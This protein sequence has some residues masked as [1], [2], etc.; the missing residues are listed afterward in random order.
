MGDVVGVLLGNLFSVGCCSIG[1]WFWGRF[2]CL[3]LLYDFG[4]V[5]GFIR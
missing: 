4:V 3:W 2:V 5:C 1:F